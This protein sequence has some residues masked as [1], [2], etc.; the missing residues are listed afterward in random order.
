[1]NFLPV[2]GNYLKWHYGRAIYNVF[3]IWENFSVFI[4][5]FFSIKSLFANFFSPWKRLTESYPKSFDLKEYFST[6]I[7]NT[8]MRAVGIVFRI[9]ML[10]IGFLCYF[11]FLITL[12]FV[13][14]IWIAFPFIILFLIVIGIILIFFS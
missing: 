14:I 7:I 3:S 11:L 1:M 2:L 9:F 13:L 5:D 10:V 6:F 8:I 4:F 12:P